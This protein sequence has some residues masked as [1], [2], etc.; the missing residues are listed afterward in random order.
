MLLITVHPLRIRIWEQIKVP[1]ARWEL[2]VMY[3][4]YGRTKDE[5]LARAGRHKAMDELLRA[6]F[7]PGSLYR[8]VKLRYRATWVE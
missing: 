2:A 5:A 4:F 3:V 7:T 1:V 6:A 8:G